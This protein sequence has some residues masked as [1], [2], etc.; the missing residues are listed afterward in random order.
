M[1][2]RNK[3]DEL[4]AR[5]G[6]SLIKPSASSQ[7]PEAVFPSAPEEKE[8][9]TKI[10]I[11]VYAD[12][13]THIDAIIAHMAKSRCRINR[14]EAIK[15]ALRGVKLTAELTTLHQEIR[16]DDGRRNRSGVK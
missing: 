12:D 15:L 11:S 6:Q 14:S 5:L 8:L 10:S 3:S 1:S 9:A 4:I 2:T 7:I 13:L 16:R